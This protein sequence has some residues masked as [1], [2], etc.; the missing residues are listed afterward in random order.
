MTSEWI[1]P[2]EARQRSGMSFFEAE[3][4]LERLQD[5]VARLRQRTDRDEV[6][7]SALDPGSH[8]VQDGRIFG[9]RVIVTSA[10]DPGEI[11]VWSYVGGLL[12]G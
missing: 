3:G 4:R 10:V 2:E 8:H 6:W 7:V 11:R 12:H 9:M 1:T 5:L